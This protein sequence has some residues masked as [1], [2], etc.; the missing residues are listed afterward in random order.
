MGNKLIQRLN[1]VPGKKVHLIPKLN[2]TVS[3]SLLQLLS[4]LS[5][6]P[7]LQSCGTMLSITPAG[8]MFTFTG[9]GIFACLLYTLRLQEHFPFP[10]LCHHRLHSTVFFPLPRLPRYYIS[11]SYSFITSDS[12]SKS[13]EK[14]LDPYLLAVI[15]G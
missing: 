7:S 8:M 1:T 15:S 13:T 3:F 2:V 12:D 9:T 4:M 10:S 11:R 14:H 6:V 5:F